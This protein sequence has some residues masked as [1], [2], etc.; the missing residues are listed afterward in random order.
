MIL[1][2]FSFSEGWRQVPQSLLERLPKKTLELP[3]GLRK[4]GKSYQNNND[5]IKAYFTYMLLSLAWK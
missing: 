2:W 4:N 3:K 1:V 5:T